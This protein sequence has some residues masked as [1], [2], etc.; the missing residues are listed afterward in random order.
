MPASCER[1]AVGEAVSVVKRERIDGE[2][3][4][5]S[6]PVGSEERVVVLNDA[7]NNLIFAHFNLR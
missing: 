1:T 7:P 3:G 6:Q 4:S 5:V 2:R